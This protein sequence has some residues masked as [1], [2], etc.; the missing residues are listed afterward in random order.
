MVK[1]WMSAR[2]READDMDWRPPAQCLMEMA[3]V[4]ATMNNQGLGARRRDALM[5]RSLSA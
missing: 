5:R 2:R 3:P 1:I 4:G